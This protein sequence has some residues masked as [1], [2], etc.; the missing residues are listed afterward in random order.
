MAGIGFELNK[1]LAR[2]GYTSMIQAYTYAGLIGSGPWLIAVLSLSLLGMILTAG[3]VG[4]ELRLLFV[5]VS[6]IYALTLVLTG[7]VQMVLT[8]YAADQHFTG[9]TEKIFPSFIF[10]LAW[11]A[12]T[13]TALGLVLFVG[14]V[15]GPLLFRLSAALLTALV[16]SV[17][18]AGV[19]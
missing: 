4:Q 16:A 11:V 9:Q 13:F 2:Q 8:R 15:P 3:G 5:A 14:F 18:V 17:W 1:L 12:A 19:F 6:L 7:P 10:S